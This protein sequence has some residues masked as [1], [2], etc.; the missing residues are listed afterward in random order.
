[1]GARRDS[2]TAHAFGWRAGRDSRGSR[3]EGLASSVGGAGSITLAGVLCA[4]AR[5]LVD[6][7]R[8][9]VG[10]PGRSSACH[11]VPTFGRL[12]G[13]VVRWSS[14]QWECGARTAPLLENSE[15]GVQRCEQHT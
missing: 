7:L 9:G 6:E 10:L 5:A 4:G 11:L 3:G 8:R 15:G 1:M 13:T 14:G 12:W 2:W